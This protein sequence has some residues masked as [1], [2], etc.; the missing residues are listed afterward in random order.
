MA[1]SFTTNY[2]WT[3][4]EVGADTN[5]WGTHLNANLSALDTTLFTVSGL[6]SAAM[7]IGGGTFTG[8]AGVSYTNPSFSISGAA[9]NTRSLLLQTAGATRWAVGADVNAESGSNLGSNLRVIRYNDGG[10]PID[11]PIIISRST[12]LVQ[13][14]DGLLVIGALTADGLLQTNASASGGSGLNIPPGAAP[15]SPNNGDFWSTSS[16]FF[17]YVNGVIQQFATAAGLGLGSLAFLSTPTFLAA[18]AFRAGQ[19]YTTP[20]VTPTATEVGYMGAPQNAQSASYTT[21]LA[22]RGK[23]IFSTG[24][25]TITVPPNSSVAY[26]IGATILVSA[27]VGVSLVVTCGGS[28]TLRFVPSNVTGSRTMTGPA[29][30]V[31]QKKKTTEWWIKGDVS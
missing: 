16:G 7:P 12:G 5:A 26:P 24:N 3:L 11:A 25:G 15:T 10:N 2:S 1:N 31:L 18:G 21:V 19:D 14:S 13:I 29:T 4:P 23:E 9:G 6:A 28:D 20:L 30:A 8:A 22:D 27:D 17:A